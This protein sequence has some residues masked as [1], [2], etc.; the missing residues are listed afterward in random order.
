MEY[1]RL[2]LYGPMNYL[3]KKLI[4]LLL[5]PLDLTGVH[6]PLTVRSMSDGRL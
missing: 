4:N 5:C 1:L 2:F 6:E 3:K